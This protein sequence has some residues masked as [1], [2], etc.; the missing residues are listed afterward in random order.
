MGFGGINVKDYQ[1]LIGKI[2]LA[3]AIIIAA[4]IVAD[5]IEYAGSRINSG[6]TYMAELVRDGLLQ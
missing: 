4:V 1:N 6:L 3:A 5:A 2:I